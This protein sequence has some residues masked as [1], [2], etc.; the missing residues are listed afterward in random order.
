MKSKVF[1][2][3]DYLNICKKTFDLPES[4]F[5]EYYT[6]IVN[7]NA[8]NNPKIIQRLENG[9]NAWFDWYKTIINIRNE[10]NPDAIIDIEKSSVALEKYPALNS[11][12]R[13]EVNKAFFDKQ[14]EV[15]KLIGKK[16]TK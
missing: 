15:I 11:G 10:Q 13:K 7:E 8:Q 9:I 12:F 14:L 4:D 3:Q 16:Q 5:L 1:K 2:Y 6:A